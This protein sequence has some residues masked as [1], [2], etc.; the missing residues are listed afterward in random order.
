[1]A[2]AVPIAVPKL[3]PPKMTTLSVAS[4]GLNALAC[5]LL[6]VLLQRMSVSQ[7]SC[8]WLRSAGGYSVLPAAPYSCLA[9]AAALAAAEEAGTLLLDAV[10]EVLV[11]LLLPA[12]L[13]L[14][15]PAAELLLLPLLLLLL[16]ELLVMI[17]FVYMGFTKL[18]LPLRLAALV[19]ACL[20]LRN[21][22][23]SWGSIPA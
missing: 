13:L 14:L 15:L 16:A 20:L 12:L 7:L 21:R 8:I 17:G 5:L 1:M 4:I 19:L 18:L 11:G 6:K 2:S 10:L 22:S 9:A 23:T 3:P